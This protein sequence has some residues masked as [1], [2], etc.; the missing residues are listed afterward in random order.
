[1]I[2]QVKEFNRQAR[3]RYQKAVDR[4]EFGK[5]GFPFL[6]M[7][8]FSNEDDEPRQ[9]GWVVSHDDRHNFYENKELAIL[10]D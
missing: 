1:M 4:F 7:Y 10:N 3:N 8:I 5:G 9:K 2:L 6:P